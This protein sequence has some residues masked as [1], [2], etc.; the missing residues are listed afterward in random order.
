MDRRHLLKGITCSFAVLPIDIPSDA[1]LG[2]GL[3]RQQARNVRIGCCC[4]MIASGPDMTGI[5][6]IDTLKQLGFD[7]IELPL[8]QMMS[9][10]AADFSVLAS[11]VRAAGIPC[12]SCNNFLPA[13]IRLTGP[14]V[15]P[16][17]IA[18]YVE[19]ALRRAAQLGAA[20]VVC[21]SG[22]SRN[23]PK[24]FPTEKAWDQMVGFLQSLDRPAAANGITIAIEAINRRETNFLNLAADGLK[25]ARQVN[26]D[27]VKLLVDYYHWAL[28]KEDTGVVLEGGDS[29]RHVH[30]ARPEGRAFPKASDPDDYAV[31]CDSLKEINYK[32]R[33]SI[34]AYTTDLNR[35]GSESLALLRRLLA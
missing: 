18:D 17:K 34:E 25:L 4:N 22:G 28:E 13:T 21:G 10:S 20:I 35:D 5:E 23:L 32:H 30:L 16:Q 8:A 7:Y 29:I 26:R 33:I 31:F 3:R 1:A 24:G 14:Q 19:A 9:L 11:R 12:E 2:A 6:T 15:E 27:N